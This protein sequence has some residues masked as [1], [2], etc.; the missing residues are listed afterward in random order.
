MPTYGVFE[1]LGIEN[2]RLMAGGLS[3]FGDDVTCD[4]DNPA[5]SLF[6]A[7]IMVRRVSRA[8]RPKLRTLAKTSLLL[9]TEVP[10]ALFIC[11][12]EF[13][14]AGAYALKAANI[15]WGVIFGGGAF[16]GFSLEEWF[17]EA[18]AMSMAPR[19]TSKRHRT[20]PV[21][22]ATFFVKSMMAALGRKLFVSVDELS[23]DRLSKRETRISWSSRGVY[24]A[25]WTVWTL[26]VSRN[27]FEADAVRV[28]V[29]A[30][31][32]SRNVEGKDSVS[33]NIEDSECSLGVIWSSSSRMRILLKTS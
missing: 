3:F 32:I 4:R 1:G 10:L 27:G 11:D 19:R 29:L 21:S 6:E 14:E 28:W 31:P 13:A 22:A 8:W 5:P 23:L 25:K 33:V 12:F 15:C 9:A 26:V 16:R 17:V 7:I 30:I 18:T 2:E 24:G 20:S